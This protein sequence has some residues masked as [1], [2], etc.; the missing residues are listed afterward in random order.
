FDIIQNNTGGVLGGTYI[1][2]D[3]GFFQKCKLI[4]I[5][6]MVILLLNFQGSEII[7]LASSEYN[8]AEKQMPRISNNVAIRI[9]CLYVIT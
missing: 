8:N 5:T 6:T 7:G 1:V 4:L 9:V 3:G 2:S